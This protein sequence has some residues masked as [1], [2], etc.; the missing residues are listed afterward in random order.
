MRTGMRYETVTYQT[1][2]SPIGIALLHVRPHC[3]C[4]V[5]PRAV[6]AQLVLRRA[7][8]AERTLLGEGKGVPASGVEPLDLLDGEVAHLLA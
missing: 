3:L 1:L 5:D 6:A 2:S 4:N 8:D 7:A